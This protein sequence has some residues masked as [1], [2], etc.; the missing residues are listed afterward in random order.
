[1]EGIS[2]S[3]STCLFAHL[4]LFIVPDTPGEAAG[5]TVVPVSR[6]HIAWFLLRKK[7]WVG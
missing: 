2:K 5:H 6:A 3:V 7:E 1:M 4:A